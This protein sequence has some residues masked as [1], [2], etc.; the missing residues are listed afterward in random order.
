M[1]QE[2]RTSEGG[3][4]AAESA[5]AEYAFLVGHLIDRETLTQAITIA[6]RWDVAPHEVLLSLRW[7]MPDDY[8]AALARYLGVSVFGDCPPDMLAG[9]VVAF[10]G[11]NGTP[12]QIAEA[13]AQREAT[14]ETALLAA[15][16]SL[17]ELEPP[18]SKAHRSK[19]AVAGLLHWRPVLSAGAPT[20]RWQ[21]IAAVLALAALAGSFVIAPGETYVSLLYFSTLA[22]LPIVLLRLVILVLGLWPMPSRA[23]TKRIPDADLPVYSILVPMFRESSVLRQLVESIAALDYPPAKLDVLLVLESVDTETLQAARALELPGFM[24]VIVVPDSQPRTKPKALNYALQFARGT[25]VVVFDAED[26]PEPDQLRRALATFQASPA[27]TAC[28]QGRLSIHNTD[29]G[30]LVRQF[31]LEY[32]VLFDVILPGL[33]RLNLP[34]PLGGTSNHFPRAILDRWTG[35][36]P[37]NVTEDADLGIRLR[38][39]GSRIGMVDSTT[40]E[41]APSRFRIWLTQRTRWLK[42]WMQTYLVHTRLPGQLYR[43]L[44]IFALIGFHLY[45]GGVLLS[46]LVFP[47]FC[48]MVGFELWNGGLLM[49]SQSV[50]DDAIWAIAIFNIAAAYFGTVIATMIAAI[51]QGKA[52]L[53]L[54]A[55]AMPLYWLLISL[56]AYR[57]LYQLMTAPHRWE[58]TEHKPR[59]VRFRT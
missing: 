19:E 12:W 1:L 34:V 38:R 35:W 32:G 29:D 41:E 15:P 21:I 39:T 9:R 33:A 40:W 54:G 37:F 46:A 25:F 55:F 14:G 22:F 50:T 57:A 43:D 52:S 2:D 31:A 10:D 18:D 20:W 24:R 42:G 6:A 51:R 3:I 28:L 23:S 13:I 59:A 44:G 30:W 27:E 48:A 58:K 56:A 47:I 11:T 8:V 26:M 17:Q 45:S 16:Q 4:S 5:E 49:P 36:D 7:I 53:A